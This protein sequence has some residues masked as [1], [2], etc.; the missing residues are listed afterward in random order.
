MYVHACRVRTVVI[1][2]KKALLKNLSGVKSAKYV[3]MQCQ[4]ANLLVFGKGSSRLIACQSI[5]IYSTS[6][7][8]L[9]VIHV[10][11]TL[12]GY[13]WSLYFICVTVIFFLFFFLFF[14]YK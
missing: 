11:L 6:G 13:R 8:I 9:S 14:L 4:N 12:T 5:V 7:A 1:Q 2:L 10:P 3:I